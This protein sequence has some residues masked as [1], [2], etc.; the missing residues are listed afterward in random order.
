MMEDLMRP[1]GQ[2]DELSRRRSPS[3]T[4]RSD[5]PP[6]HLARDNDRS[7]RWNEKARNERGLQPMRDVILL[8]LDVDVDAEKLRTLI[9]SLADQVGARLAVP[10]QDV[11]VIRDRNTGMSKGFG[12]AKFETLEDAKRFVT[13]HAPFISNAEHWLGPAPGDTDGK[14]RRKRI[15]VDYSNSERPQGGV[16]YYEQHN[17][18]GCKEQQKRRT[19]R[20]RGGEHEQVDTKNENPGLR[21]ASAFPTSM[22]L[23]TNVDRELRAAEIG[24]AL[25]NLPLAPLAVPIANALASALAQ[26]DQILVVRDRATYRSMSH[27]VAVFKDMDA[28]RAVLDTMR[29]TTIFPDG[30]VLGG[31]RVRTSFADPIVFEEADPYDPTCAPWTYTDAEQRIWRYENERLG[32]EMWDAKTYTPASSSAMTTPASTPRSSISTDILSSSVEQE[33]KS[34]IDGVL[35]TLIT[36]PPPHAALRG[37]NF[38]DKERLVCLLCQRQFKNA[39]L[40]ARHAT[41][42]GLHR[43]NLDDEHACRAGAARVQANQYMHIKENAA[44][45][46]FAPHKHPGTTATRKIPSQS[47]ELRRLALQPMGWN[48]GA[49]DSVLNPTTLSFITRANAEP[50]APMH[51]QRAPVSTMY[52]PYV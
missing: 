14:I 46:F 42:S 50:W 1:I 44:V 20:T 26:L 17:A 15:K 8:G 11:T 25:Y 24:T 41:E 2:Q 5:S 43:T 29:N 10:P 52:P 45:P 32:L 7:M 31:Q 49:T 36:L 37:I 22:L 21:D 35:T 4:Q 27:A 3:P 16:S 51:V 13:V 38:G 9:T 48:V 12:F 40:L 18:P 39:E 33:R 28:A 47:A 34:S 30:I 19:R 23:L 6:L